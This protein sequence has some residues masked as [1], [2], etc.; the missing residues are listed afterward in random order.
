M[1][2]AW[3]QAGHAEHLLYTAKWQADQG[4]PATRPTISRPGSSAEMA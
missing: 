3:S 4:P 2:Q 1:T